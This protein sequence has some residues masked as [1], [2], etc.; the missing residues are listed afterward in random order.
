MHASAD[1]NTIG[2]YW[3]AADA[4]LGGAFPYMDWCIWPKIYIGTEFEMG[5]SYNDRRWVV[6]LYPGWGPTGGL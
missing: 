4:S 6:A 1:A 5:G 3:R 2:G